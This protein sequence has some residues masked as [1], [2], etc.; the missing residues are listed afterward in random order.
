MATPNK[1]MNIEHLIGEENDPQQRAILI[2]LNNINLSLMATT[3][4]TRSL[5]EKFDA[6][7]TDYEA[8]RNK[9]VGAWRVFV[10]GIGIAQAVSFSV[11]MWMLQDLASLHSQVISGQVTDARHTERIDQMARPKN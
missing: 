1:S 2:I 11:C 4:T 3:E 7:M 8:L 5:A 9:G 6:H 10:W